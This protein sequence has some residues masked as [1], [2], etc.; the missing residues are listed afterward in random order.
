MGEVY[1]HGTN[2]LSG[3]PFPTMQEINIDEYNYYVDGLKKVE[4]ACLANISK[5][6]DLLAPTMIDFSQDCSLFENITGEDENSFEY[7]VWY[8]QMRFEKDA[9]AAVDRMIYDFEHFDADEYHQNARAL[10]ESISENFEEYE[11]DY[12]GYTPTYDIRDLSRDG[13][14]IMLVNEKYGYGEDDTRQWLIMRFGSK[15][16][17]V[18]YSGSS[19]LGEYTDLYITKLKA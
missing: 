2:D 13:G 7:N 3:L 8:Y 6:H 1:L 17:R 12:D 14:E 10:A 18:S 19:N 9:K 16:I 4:G 5:S 15:Y 11:I